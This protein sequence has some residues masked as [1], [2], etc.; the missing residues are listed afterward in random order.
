MHKATLLLLLSL[1]CATAAAMPPS[2]GGATWRQPSLDEPAPHDRPL[3]VYFGAEWCPPCKVLEARAFNQPDVQAALQPFDAVY[4]DGDAV[5]AKEWMDRYK[6]VGF[7]TLL[8]IAPDGRELGRVA[9]TAKKQDVVDFLVEASG[10]QAPMAIL[11]R[12]VGGA[13]LDRADWTALAAIPVHG[14]DTMQKD[15]DGASVAL[16]R[17]RDDMAA[18]VAAMRRVEPPLPQAVAL[19]LEAKALLLEV[20]T[21]TPGE[22]ATQRATLDAAMDDAAA[23]ADLTSELAYFSQETLDYL[24]PDEDSGRRALARRFIAMM[25]AESARFPDDAPLQI[26][27]MQMQIPLLALGS[28][29]IDAAKTRIANQVERILETT[30]TPADRLA[31]VMGAAYLLRST[32]REFRSDAAIRDALK[33]APDAYYLHDVLAYG[34]YLR[35]DFEEGLRQTEAAFRGAIDSPSAVQWGAGWIG[36][37]VDERSGE[38]ATIER[39]ANE[40]LDAAQRSG[41]PF[42]GYNV[43][44]MTRLATEL[45]RW[46]ALNAANAAAGARIVARIERMCGQTRDEAAQSKACAETV[47]TF[48]K[49]P[50]E[51][52]DEGMAAAG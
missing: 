27:M 44:P 24:H 34:A 12:L 11:Q 26:L 41:G 39:A 23:L 10:T 49:P 22:R 7:P 40:V 17:F 45:G 1:A 48:R 18:A 9:G 51:D 52:A 30:A 14:A 37:L 29:D 5:D 31:V 20:M 19:R 8:A 4:V 25:D 32:G 46:A 36:W 47:E 42:R 28:D 43:K 16:K 35:G 38:P 13:P 3:L 2:D 50:P 33:M 15:A 6:V 21:K